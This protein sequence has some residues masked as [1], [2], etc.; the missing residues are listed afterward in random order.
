MRVL[1]LAT[2]A[3]L[4]TASP[5]LAQ[6]KADTAAVIQA[7]QRLFDGMHRQDTSA[8]RSVLLPQAQ[9]YGARSAADSVVRPTAAD[10]FVK[11][12]GPGGPVMLERMWQP[13]VRIEGPVATVWAPYDFHHGSQFSHCGID[14]FTLIQR[15]DGWKIAGIVFTVQ[16]TGCKPSPLGAPK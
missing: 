9:L 4:A 13:Q 14:A 2:V 1:I 12:F 5:L 16:P 8:I 7:V 10:Q 11:A 15:P 3:G 6:A